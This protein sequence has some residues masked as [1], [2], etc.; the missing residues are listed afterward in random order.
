MKMS[1]IMLM[2]VHFRAHIRRG[3]DVQRPVVRGEEPAVQFA[4]QQ[5]S[6]IRLR[7]ERLGTKRRRPTS[8]QW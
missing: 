4:S 1:M 6:L 5:V 2:L 7:K 8:W 3:W